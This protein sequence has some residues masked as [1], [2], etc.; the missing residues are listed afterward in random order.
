MAKAAVQ[1]QSQ[2]RATKPQSRAKAMRA[3]KPRAKAMRATKPQSR[4]KAMRATK[5]QSRAT[6]PQSRAKATQS[7]A[8]AP[9]SRALVLPEFIRTPRGDAIRFNSDGWKACVK[10]LG[11][12]YKSMCDTRKPSYQLLHVNAYESML[13]GIEA[14]VNWYIGGNAYVTITA[15]QS[16]GAWR[17]PGVVLAKTKFLQV[18]DLHD[19]DV[20]P[21]T[22]HARISNIRW[23]GYTNEFAAM[24]VASRKELGKKKYDRLMEMLTFYEDCLDARDMRDEQDRR[25]AKP[26]SRP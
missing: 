10:F 18:R 21:H 4:A 1:R 25:T 17:C 26:Q 6:K 11:Q 9:Q 3:T 24:T 16:R 20:G 13:H 19:A 7:R 23:L 12:D 5:P 8:K 14:D 2:S 15:P 22:I